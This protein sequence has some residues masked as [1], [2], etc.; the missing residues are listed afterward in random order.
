MKSALS[1]PRSPIVDIRAAKYCWQL[2]VLFPDTSRIPK[3]NDDAIPDP[4]YAM[5]VIVFAW[6][7]SQPPQRII[8]LG[9]HGLN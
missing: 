3:P 7:S 1:N 5:P 4:K 8:Q 9:H 2:G 6:W